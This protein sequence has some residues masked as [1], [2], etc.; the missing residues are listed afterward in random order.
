VDDNLDAAEALAMVLRQLGH[1]VEFAITGEAALQVARRMKAQLVFLDLSLPGM[2]GYD[3]ASALRRE[4][5][6]AIRI[7]AL[8]GYGRDE[9]QRRS[10][11]AG[12]DAYYV[13]PM[14][15]EVLESV[16]AALR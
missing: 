4:F 11:R 2:S 16:L 7:I 13:K 6:E 5:G 14:E 8:S 3:V 10:S 1:E 15:M 12:C 9:D